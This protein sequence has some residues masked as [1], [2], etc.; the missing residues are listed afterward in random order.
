MGTRLAYKTKKLTRRAS[1]SVCLNTCR[2]WQPIISTLRKPCLKIKLIHKGKR[3]KGP[4]AALSLAQGLTDLTALTV[5]KPGG[6]RK[7]L[8]GHKINT[9]ETNS[10]HSVKTEASCPHNWWSSATGLLPTPL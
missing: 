8:Q 7:L 2:T 9:G 4:S 1:P 5:G 10:N 6:P 3:G